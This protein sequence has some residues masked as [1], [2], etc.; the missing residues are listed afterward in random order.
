MTAVAV[1]EAEAIANELARARGAAAECGEEC[2]RPDADVVHRLADLLCSRLAVR[3]IGLS[4]P[5]FETCRYQVEVSTARN[6]SLRSNNQSSIEEQ[7]QAR[8]LR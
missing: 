2:E 1:A 5:G 3:T 8:G 4:S 7:K 6:G